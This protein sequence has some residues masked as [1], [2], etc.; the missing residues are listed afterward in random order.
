MPLSYVKA[1]PATVQRTPGATGSPED[2]NLSGGVSPSATQAHDPGAT[3]TIV[4][5]DHVDD[6]LGARTPGVPR[7]SSR[8]GGSALRHRL[9]RPSRPGP[10][11]R[12]GPR[13][14]PP[15]RGWT[16]PRSILGGGATVIGRPA[17]NSALARE[18]PARLVAPSPSRLENEGP[19]VVVGASSVQL[20]FSC[21]YLARRA[22]GRTARPAGR[23]GGSHDRHVASRWPSAALASSK[24]LVV[25]RALP[26]SRSDRPPTS[27]STS[28]LARVP[29]TVLP[30]MSG[31]DRVTS[32]CSRGA[33]PVVRGISRRG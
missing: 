11:R 21:R 10:P 8:G 24:A 32:S 7:A 31:R 30:I 9:C 17:G 5:S 16:D 6:E 13:R 25:Q 1:H 14:R 26:A 22:A 23:Q 4:D 33:V 2:S 29:G 19:D 18:N 20:L 28:V 12:R 3:G 27:A 15:V